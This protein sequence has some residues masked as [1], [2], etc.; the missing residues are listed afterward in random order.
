M[1][2]KLLDEDGVKYLWKKIN[3]RMNDIVCAGLHQCQSCGA[4]YQ[5]KANCEY[6]GRGFFI[7]FNMYKEHKDG[8]TYQH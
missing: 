8:Y 2:M 5:G 3:Q 7:D 4:P 6:C 1:S